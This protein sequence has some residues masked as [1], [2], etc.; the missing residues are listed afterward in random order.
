MQLYGSQLLNLGPS[1]MENFSV[2]W[3]KAICC[4]LHLPR[5]TQNCHLLNH[6]CHDDSIPSFR[7]YL[8]TSTNYGS[9]LSYSLTMERQLFFPQRNWQITQKLI[10]QKL[11]SFEGLRLIITELLHMLYDCYY[12]H[13]DATPF[14]QWGSLSNAHPYVSME[15]SI[16]HCTLPALNVSWFATER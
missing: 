11:I 13:Y 16:V 3:R 9:C 10:Y 4:V 14:S 15:F 12:P 5:R 8:V 2:A 7:K 1:S 6:I